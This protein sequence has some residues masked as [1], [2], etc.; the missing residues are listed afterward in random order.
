MSVQTDNAGGKI[1]IAVQLLL[2]YVEE[3]SQAEV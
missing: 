1:P 3:S 2:R